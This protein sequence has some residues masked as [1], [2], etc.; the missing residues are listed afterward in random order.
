MARR[1]SR[2]SYK[3]DLETSRDGLDAARRRLFEDQEAHKVDL[4]GSGTGSSCQ[5]S[6]QRSRSKFLNAD[7]DTSPISIIGIGISLCCLLIIVLSFCKYL[8]C[9]FSNSL[10]DCVQKIMEQVST[11][12]HKQTKNKYYLIKHIL[13][14]RSFSLQYEDKKSYVFRL[15]QELCKHIKIWVSPSPVSWCDMKLSLTQ[16]IKLQILF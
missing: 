9:V 7:N 16:L 15:I 14:T 8:N 4:G 5:N 1:S 10:H 2:L 11:I 6:H 13:L 12:M 3:K